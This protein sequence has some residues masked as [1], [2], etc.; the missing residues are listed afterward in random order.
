MISMPIDPSTKSRIVIFRPSIGGDLHLKLSQPWKRSV[1]VG[2]NVNF[3]MA[4][5]DEVSQA[6]LFYPSVVGQV[7]FFFSDAT[8]T[9]AD[10]TISNV[11]IVQIDPDQ[12]AFDTETKASKVLTY[13][14]G[15]ADARR[16][17]VLPK[18]GAIQV[19]ER[20]T[21]PFD[22]QEGGDFDANGNGVIGAPE[23]VNICLGAMGITGL[24]APATMFPYPAPTKL[25]W[26]L[27]HAPTELVKLLKYT[28]HNFFVDASGNPQITK[29]GSGNLP[30]ISG[31]RLIAQVPV[32]LNETRANIVVIT[33]GPLAAIETRTVTGFAGSGWEYVVRDKDRH[34]QS[35]TDSSWFDNVSP[36]ACIKNNF[37]DVPEEFRDQVRA[38]LYHCVRLQRNAFGRAPICRELFDSD[39]SNPSVIIQREI[40][41]S[42]NVMRYS[43]DPPQWKNPDSPVRLSVAMIHGGSVL[44]FND[45]LGKVDTSNGAT[46]TSDPTQNFAELS[47]SDLS[48][49]LSREVYEK[50]D[51][52][53]Y[54]PVFYAA[55]F[56][57][58]SIGPQLLDPD[59]AI[60]Q[61]SAP[62]AIVV[63]RPDFRPVYIDGVLANQSD[64]NNKAAAIAP[65]FLS[66]VQ[67]SSQRIV[68]SGFW[69]LELGGR[70]ESV[71]YDQQAL[72][73]TIFV[74]TFWLPFADYAHE[75]KMVDKLDPGEKYPLQAATA[76]DRIGNG[77]TGFVQP[78]VIVNSPAV[79]PPSAKI[80]KVKITAPG[81][82][83]GMY[84]GV[85]VGGMSTAS[86]GSGAW[87]DEP[88]GMTPG[89]NHILI[90]N[91][92]ED[93]TY[94]D[95]SGTNVKQILPI[96]SEHL[97]KIVGGSNG[98]VVEI[99]SCMCEPDPSKGT[100][101]QVSNGG[102]GTDATASTQSDDGCERKIVHVDLCTR[103]VWDG[104]NFTFFKRTLTL[105]CGRVASISA[106]TQVLMT[107]TTAC[108]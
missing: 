79:P 59:A 60:L 22:S 99:E 26:R 9:E 32:A 48:V 49:R 44:R 17:Y 16:S 76:G 72:T 39:P 15:F 87:L 70:V 73:T 98:T 21:E 82:N 103:A 100:T 89:T 93:T 64:L 61:L 65:A 13:R 23:A 33:S 66:P 62:E 90:L 45:L 34:W 105:N 11:A 25:E 37:Q 38:D 41:V 81:T 35:L 92:F 95:G 56:E 1:G 74:D 63:R 55:A 50:D 46:T 30:G 5:A 4:R 104:T 10:L 51:K 94:V 78:G 6:L 24:S 54:A 85:V 86:D 3:A 69:G 52:G 57:Q 2:P 12:Y 28:Q 71:E 80:V 106:E 8:L 101:F 97:G 27:A 75:L 7:L 91:L 18:G 77:D 42:A 29:I 84:Q 96:G 36:P 40:D 108:S 31:S 58:T 43:D 14:F 68:V 53:D 20:N 102:G 47:G 88:E 19:G 67:G 107:T 83:G